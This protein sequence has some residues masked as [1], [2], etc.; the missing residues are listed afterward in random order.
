VVKPWSGFPREVVNAPSVETSKARL[1][2]ALSTLIQLKMSLQGGWARWPLKVPAKPKH[3]VILNF[4]ATEIIQVMH[5]LQFMIRCEIILES[6][7]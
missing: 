4:S 6:T 2:G 1:D 3:S 7:Y 5:R